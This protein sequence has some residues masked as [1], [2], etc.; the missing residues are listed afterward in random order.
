[1]RNARHCSLSALAYW[2]SGDRETRHFTCA[3]AL[4]V[5]QLPVSREIGNMGT[6]THF[7]GCGVFQ[8]LRQLQFTPGDIMTHSRGREAVMKRPLPRKIGKKARVAG[9]TTAAMVLVVIFAGM[10]SANKKEKVVLPDYLWKAKTVLV[11]IL[12][13]AVE[14]TDDPSAN[15]RSQEEVEKALMKW[16]RFQLTLDA[17]LADLVIGVRKGTG[18]IAN[19]TVNGGPVDSRPGTVEATDDAIRVGVTKGRPPDVTQPGGPLGTNGTGGSTTDKPHT[20]VEVGGQDDMFKVFHGKVQYAVDAA[21]VWRYAEKDGLKAP[22]VKAV[23]EFRKAV[24]ESEKAA[25][26]KQQQQQQPGKTP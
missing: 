18:K 12:P 8:D 26:Q 6:G 20:G 2:D 15:R 7:G 14:P 21:P 9:T 22:E 23:A 19:P 25:A 4:T 3:R 11:V 1:M 16:G 10:A 24:E 5:R 13:D 17:G